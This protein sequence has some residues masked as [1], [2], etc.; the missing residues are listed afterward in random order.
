M[1]CWCNAL[2][3]NPLM[4]F[5][6]ETESAQRYMP[7][8][9][10]VLEIWLKNFELK[11]TH[12]FPLLKSNKW[13]YFLMWNKLR[14]ENRKEYKKTAQF[15]GSWNY[16]SFS[17][18][19]LFLFQYF[20]CIKNTWFKIFLFTAFFPHLCALEDFWKVSIA[21]IKFYIFFR[22]FLVLFL[23]PSGWLL[24]KHFISCDHGVTHLPSF[25]TISNIGA[26]FSPNKVFEKFC[27]LSRFTFRYWLLQYGTLYPNLHCNPFSF[28]ETK[29]KK[30]RCNFIKTSCSP[31]V[32]FSLTAPFAP[33]S[34]I[35]RRTKWGIEYSH[36]LQETHSLFLTGMNF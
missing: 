13:R 24:V 4:K 33:S 35:P 27:D 21:S 19:S 2:V 29:F 30:Y 15:S 36:S 6:R 31:I 3:V 18:F 17:H 5:L 34:F 9:D 26:N 25:P 20:S 10:S 22:W 11:H 1:K 14:K 28:L 32:S 7:W 16:F 23:N 8:W 12:P